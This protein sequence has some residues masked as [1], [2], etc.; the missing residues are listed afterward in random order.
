MKGVETPAPPF[1]RLRGFV[2]NR[3]VRCHRFLPRHLARS[4]ASPAGILDRRFEIAQ[5]AQMPTVRGRIG[6]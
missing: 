5:A 3:N 6:R 4:N 2:N 1:G